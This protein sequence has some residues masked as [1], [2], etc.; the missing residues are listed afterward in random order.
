MLQRCHQELT[1]KHAVQDGV[2]RP[3][4]ERKQRSPIVSVRTK[5]RRHIPCQA[6]PAPH[7][8]AAPQTVHL[9]SSEAPE[10]LRGMRRNRAW[11]AT[12]QEPLNTKG[13]RWKSML[14][15]DKAAI[16]E[17]SRTS[18][19]GVHNGFCQVLAVVI[20]VGERHR[21]RVYVLG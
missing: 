6:I 18:L 20:T 21:L 14:V 9:C 5:L 1:P 7:R 13:H 17:S 2:A 15:F 3:S 11:G 8:E 4:M 16:G 12:E 19:V 10:H